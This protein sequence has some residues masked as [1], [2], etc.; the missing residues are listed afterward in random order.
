MVSNSQVVFFFK[1]S[2]HMDQSISIGVDGTGCSSCNDDVQSSTS[3][4]TTAGPYYYQTTNS[5]VTC[6]YYCLKDYCSFSTGN[7][8]SCIS[9]QEPRCYNN[10]VGSQEYSAGK[11]WDD[12]NGECQGYSDCFYWTSCSFVYGQSSSSVC[13]LQMAG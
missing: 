12:W 2:L 6:P 11:C 9:E 1:V 7:S 10:A 13:G 3:P 8:V 5:G 4:P